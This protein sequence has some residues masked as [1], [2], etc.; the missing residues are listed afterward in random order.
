MFTQLQP[1][2]S[3]PFIEEFPLPETCKS[4]AGSEFRPGETMWR[5]SDIYRKSSFNFDR[6]SN[7]LSPELLH[8]LKH[9]LLH[10][11]QNGSLGLGQAVFTRFRGFI[12]YIAPQNSR[13]AAIRSVDVL[14][15]RA[16]L[17]KRK[18]YWLSTV[19][20]FL[21]KW[22]A[23][24]FPGIE[25][26]VIVLL[27]E[28]R[29]KNP[30]KGEAVRTRDPKKGAFSGV[31]FSAIHTGLH[32][33]LGRREISLREF[34]LA[35]LFLGFGHR[36]VQLAMLICGD[37]RCKTQPNGSQKYELM[38]PLA[39][40][41]GE[42]HGAVLKP[43]S[44]IPEMGQA[45]QALINEV[46]TVART[47]L[48]VAEGDLLNLPL[49]PTWYSTHESGFN[50]HTN[51]VDLRVELERALGR[52]HIF[53]ERTGEPLKVTSHRF[54]HT[55][56]TRAAEEG[57]GVPVIAEMLGQTT[58]ASALIYAECTAQV[59]DRIN[60][61]TAFELAPLAQAFAG[62]IV[63]DESVAVRGDDPASRTG[64]GTCGKCGPCIARAPIAC[65][66]CI[67]FQAWEDGDHQGLLDSVISERDRLLALGDKHRAPLYDP[68][69]LAIAQVILK[70]SAIKREK[71]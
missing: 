20:T 28:I 43:Y 27:G 13:I 64:S 47:K 67:K 11:L 32:H 44:L 14:N 39:K 22:D 71:V 4:F 41:E 40:L 36:A 9:T 31:E 19:S 18:E 38:M 65:Y 5:L 35:Q 17:G 21:R 26:D 1:L 61:S 53:S 60:E 42:R 8:A 2:E 34:V 15:W 37:L 33:A 68:T 66:T 48:V 70:I 49:F 29:I 59:V 58:T 54:R 45:T 56:G 63:K 6:F 55:V 30:P 57:L 3:I 51:S 52:L 24:G 12:K 16:H 25:T 62:K 69:I 23:L 10:Y 7:T 50:H 46:Q